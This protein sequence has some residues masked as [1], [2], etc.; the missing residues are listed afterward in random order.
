MA[1]A[2]RSPATDAAAAL[3]RALFDRGIR[4]F[5]V[6]PG[7][8]SQAL[9]LA[10]A[11]LEKHGAALHVRIDERV[12]G[13]TALGIGRELRVP[14]A[15]ICTSGTAVANLLP[16]VLEA[17]HAGVPL[18]LLTAD[19]PPEL[20]GIGANQ[21]TRQVGIFAPNVRYEADLPVPD[22]TDAAGTSSQTMMLR[23]VAGAA[24]TAALGDGAWA[25]GPVHLNLPYREPLAGVLPEW[26][27]PASDPKSP[28]PNIADVEDVANAS[29][30][31][32]QGGGGIGEVCELDGAVEPFSLSRGPRTI[33]I[34]GAD[35][36]S[37][38]EQ[39]AHD[40]SWPLVAEI[41]SGSR[42]GRYL[43]HGY[44]D[45]LR[46][47]GGNVERA[48]VF[49][50]PTLSREVVALLSR[51][52][53]E[54]IAVR[55]PGEP[56]NL[57][58]ATVA[59]ESVAVR[60]GDADREWLGQW[61]R[62]SRA[63]SVDLAPP[64]PDADALS[65]AEP[66]ERLGAIA[67]ELGVIRAPLDRAALVDAVWR[68]TWPHDRLMF[69]SSRLV[70]VADTVLA[71]KKVP[72]HANRGL[73]GIDGTVATA[74]GIALASQIAG[75][76]GVTRAVL[77]DLA[78]LYDVGAL[79]LPLQEPAPRLQLIV[80]NDRG[81]TIF[82]G[83]EVASVAS[84]AAFS[85]VQYTPHNANLEQ[86]AAAYGWEFHRPKTR[87]ELDQ[88]LTGHVAGRQLIEVTLER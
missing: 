4:H 87:G 26:F 53:V 44:R 65:S 7:S 33:V 64:A 76:P 18:L 25:A 24:V 86:L 75:S 12:A 23:D 41:V 88:V 19:R 39:L 84:D 3:V 77:G 49:G 58:G 62:A 85:R 60:A 51:D 59:A 78:F 30:A 45:V 6:S 29:G 16:A 74:M 11:E 42:F 63:A 40:G 2:K 83:L 54:V 8:R 82:D 34:A 15:V 32:Y 43:V 5:V 50:H 79:L 36:T 73:A 48:V 31:L 35:A 67:A 66:R 70:R 71:G 1:E 28:E 47:L 20:R 72:V 80:G 27:R 37:A 13:F 56:L 52:D 46:Q 81:G 14:A 17:H 22:E 69:G 38:A 55:G 9:A 57:N 61:M 10:A 68:A 21:A